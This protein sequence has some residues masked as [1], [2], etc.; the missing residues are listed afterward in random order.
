MTVAGQSKQ[1]GGAQCLSG[2][3][4]PVQILNPELA[5]QEDQ[6]SPFSERNS[7][8]SPC[9]HRMVLAIPMGLVS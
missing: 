8:S 6:L 1:R 7:E 4:D 2:T 3:T 9:L 5:L